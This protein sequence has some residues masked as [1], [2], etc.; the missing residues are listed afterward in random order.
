[1][2]ELIVRNQVSVRQ[3][4]ERWDKPGLTMRKG[5]D[6][7]WSGRWW[8]GEGV[9]RTGAGEGVGEGGEGEG[10][11]VGVGAGGGNVGKEVKHRPN[12]DMVMCGP[13]KKNHFPFGCA[14]VFLEFRLQ[15]HLIPSGGLGQAV[16]ASTAAGSWRRGSGGV[17]LTG[18]LLRA[19]SGAAAGGRVAWA[20]AARGTG[21]GFMRA[22][23]GLTMGMGTLGAS[24]F[25]IKNSSN[26]MTQMNYT[27]KITESCHNYG[28]PLRSHMMM[29]VLL[30]LLF[31][32]LLSINIL[33]MPSF[34]YKFV[35]PF[36]FHCYFTMPCPYVS[37][38]IK[39]CLNVL[40]SST[41]CLALVFFYLFWSLASSN[42]TIKFESNKTF[43]TFSLDPWSN[44]R[45]HQDCPPILH[46]KFSNQNPLK[47]SPLNIEAKT[48]SFYYIIIVKLFRQIY[49]FLEYVNTKYIVREY[50]LAQEDLH[51]SLG[52]TAI[53][54]SVDPLKMIYS[55]EPELATHS[56]D[57]G[58][59]HRSFSQLSNTLNSCQ[60]CIKRLIRTLC[61][62]PITLRDPRH[63]HSRFILF[64]RN[65]YPVLR[66]HLQDFFTTRGVINPCLT[67]PRR[68]DLL[69][70]RIYY[71]LNPGVNSVI[72][73]I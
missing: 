41:T 29:L 28:L 1:M 56:T 53:P 16:L 71:E 27:P 51:T 63:Q 65:P 46:L 70:D 5:W 57:P 66:L 13:G 47:S 64:L 62:F 14:G 50:P 44:L 10:A 21:L 40:V 2:F 33:L 22:E 32:M 54:M 30:P 68:S 55:C 59:A 11:G 35:M 73:P 23:G 26:I 25:G 60:E 45:P 52:R 4:L 31:L 17:L 36:I 38:F 67:G 24:S 72:L 42:K 39:I 69:V 9:D 3:F 43:A 12:F 20:A 58:S 7:V 61:V 37:F 6:G 48:N 18:S 49:M 8:A 15:G 34:H 19:S